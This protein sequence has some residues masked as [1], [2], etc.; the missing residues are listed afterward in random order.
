MLATLHTGDARRRLLEATF[1]APPDLDSFSACVPEC[2]TEALSNAGPFGTL[3]SELVIKI[4]WF[5]SSFANDR[6]SGI[7]LHRSALEAA[8]D[9]VGFA[10]SC[11]FALWVFRSSGRRLRLE[12]VGRC[13]TAVTPSRGRRG[14]EQCAYY[15][16][17]LREELSRF[18]I[19]LL[20]GAINALVCH[21]TGE[22]CFSARRAHNLIIGS[23]SR[24]RTEILRRAAGEERPRIKVAWRLRSRRVAAA[25]ESQTAAV[26][27]ETEEV[28]AGSASARAAAV[29]ARATQIRRPPSLFG[30]A[31]YLSSH[32]SSG[33]ADPDGLERAPSGVLVVE[34]APRSEATA[35]FEARPTHALPL[36][37]DA[38]RPLSVAR[39]RMSPCGEWLALVAS[40][41]ALPTDVA[42]DTAGHSEVRVFSLRKHDRTPPCQVLDVSLGGLARD[43]GRLST[44]RPD[45]G[46]SH[47]DVWF[48]NGGCE[49]FVLDCSDAQRGTNIRP[50]SGAAADA[51]PRK[52][53]L[54]RFQRYRRLCPAGASPNEFRPADVPRIDAFARIRGLK[55]R[56]CDHSVVDS[57]VSSS[58]L[59]IVTIWNWFYSFNPSGYGFNVQHFHVSTGKWE[60]VLRPQ[61]NTWFENGE[62]A[63]RR[64][65]LTPHSDT[66]V[67]LLQTVIGFAVR[68]EIYARRPQTDGEHWTTVVEEAE[69]RGDQC[70]GTDFGAPFLCVHQLAVSASIETPIS[71]MKPRCSATASPCGRFVLFVFKSASNHLN[72]SGG[73][74]VIDLGEKP[75]AQALSYVWMPALSYALPNDLSWNRAGLWLQT[76]TGVLLV[77]T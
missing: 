19:R 10:L 26:V 39:L 13:C 18:H 77:G 46:Q 63:P 25:S 16:Q 6:Q 20:E 24:A 32:L 44:Q 21:C 30:P 61:K 70:S 66:A 49:L 71:V 52:P 9:V 45:D 72:S 64:C 68:I 42:H 69:I 11:R 37:F 75:A 3:S 15:N 8:E 74:Y 38:E 76:H 17:V 50:S 56:L 14:G 12:I 34:N 36:S 7:L 41:L 53:V 5:A 29:A 28:A 67:L 47:I 55:S 22:H 2:S 33:Q 48:A 23:P 73:V 35:H 51:F 58:G 60:T 4:L 1:R 31:G 59:G 40:T 62:Y 54:H 27:L 43:I 57:S 65:V